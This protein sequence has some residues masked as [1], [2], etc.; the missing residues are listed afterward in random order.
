MV[1]VTRKRAKFKAANEALEKIW[2]S[3]LIA[4]GRQREFHVQCTQIFR[5]IKYPVKR[6]QEAP[7]DTGR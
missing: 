6:K 7:H 3:H 5:A 2:R 4:P 1:K